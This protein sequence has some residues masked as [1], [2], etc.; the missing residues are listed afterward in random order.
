MT[1]P[2]KEWKPKKPHYIPRP[3]GKSFKYHCFQCPFTCNEKSH[4]F[5]HM[6]YDLCK[7][8]LSLLSKQGKSSMNTVT[9]ETATTEALTKNNISLKT[10]DL[11]ERTTAQLTNDHKAQPEDE[12]RSNTAKSVKLPQRDQEHETKAGLLTK[13]SHRSDGVKTSASSNKEEPEA[14]THTFQ[15]DPTST[16]HQPSKCLQQPAIPMYN[17]IHVQ[18]PFLIDYKSQ[19]QAKETE[20][21]YPSNAFHYSLYPIHS[22]YSPYFLHGNYCNSPHFTPQFTPHIMNALPH[23]IH[24][25]FPGHLLPIPSIP[26]I[27]STI[28]DKSY[29]FYPSPSLSM[30]HLPDQTHLTL[31]SHPETHQSIMGLPSSVLHARHNNVQFDS[32]NMAHRECLPRPEPGT[33]VS[34]QD[35]VHMSP[36]PGYS[37]TGSPSGPNATAHTQNTTESQKPLNVTGIVS[38]SEQLEEYNT[39]PLSAEDRSGKHSSMIDQER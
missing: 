34:Q 8:S 9:M 4:L 26:T 17:P 24:P 7:N 2:T 32:C 28:L 21:F 33:R 27:P 37:P 6:K 3:A 20:S 30:Y 12:E 23:G 25:L 11:E 38:S 29:R 15:E 14:T 22:S 10:T 18:N 36:L 31:C 16:K 19:K 39:K 13:T 35:K 1:A 5:N